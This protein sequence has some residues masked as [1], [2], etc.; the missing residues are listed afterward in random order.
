[1]PKNLGKT[2]GVEQRGAE[3]GALGAREASM[4]A[5]LA[6]VVE[7]WPTLPEA[8]K[9]GILAMVRSIE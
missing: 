8:F 6:T 1:M 3:S 7:A 5:E 4:D 2:R 9:V